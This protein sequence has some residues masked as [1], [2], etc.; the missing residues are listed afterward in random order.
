MDASTI[1]QVVTM[2]GGGPG[3]STETLNYFIYRQGFSFLDM[4]YASAMAWL[5]LTL[6]LMRN[7][8]RSE[9]LRYQTHHT[10]R[11]S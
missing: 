9:A 8:G 4:G 5:L 6:W 11:L 10:R 2:T 7:L 3:N 1:D